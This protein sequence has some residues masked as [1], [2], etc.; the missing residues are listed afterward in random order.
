MRFSIITVCWNSEKTLPTAMG[1][2][3]MQ[4]F[5]DYEWIVI[6]GASTDATLNIARTFSAAPAYIISE[7][8]AGIYDAMNK[9]VRATKGVILF[10]LNSDDAFCDE[11]VLRDVSI[12][13]EAY[14]WVDLL[15]GNVVYQYAARRVLRTFEHIN[16]DTLI[17]E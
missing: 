4:C 7:P 17:F 1:S 15:F 10:F 12:L 2:L 14:P 3:S 13:Y 9:G 8:D 16:D 11:N 5:K 6:D